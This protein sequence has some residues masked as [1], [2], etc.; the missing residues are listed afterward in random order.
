MD[1]SALPAPSDAAAAKQ[2]AAF[3]TALGNASTAEKTLGELDAFLATRVFAAGN[4]FSSSDLDLYGV[5]RPLLAAKKDKQRV[6]HVN[7]ARWFDH[8]QHQPL[9]S[10][11]VQ[12][13]GGQVP[14]ARPSA[15]LPLPRAVVSSS[16]AAAPAAA[17]AT[18]AAAAAAVAAAPAAAAPEEAKAATKKADAKAAAAPAAP[19]ATAT[20]P[21]TSDAKPAKAAPAATGDAAAAVR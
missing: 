17:P 5:V 11:A 7:V 21:A 19:A 20:A 1:A 12:A 14:I 8:V 4:G 2:I 3:A 16:S 15:P 9:M 10:A 6:Q 18:P 13:A